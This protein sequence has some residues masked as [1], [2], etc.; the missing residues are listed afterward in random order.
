MCLF[1]I[2]PS[3]KTDRV[4][5]ALLISSNFILFTP[6]F[7]VANAFLV[8]QPFAC[9]DAQIQ[10]KPMGLISQALD[11]DYAASVEDKKASRKSCSVWVFF[12]SKD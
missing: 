3:A 8:S 2:L 5:T 12:P 6:G 7:T 11:D 9:S 1:F 10:L 4:K